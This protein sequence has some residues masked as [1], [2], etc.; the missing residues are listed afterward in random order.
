MKPL[1]VLPRRAGLTFAVAAVVFRRLVIALMVF[2]GFQEFLAFSRGRTPFLF[3]AGF[4][5]DNLHHSSG[6][7]YGTSGNYKDW[8]RGPE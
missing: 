2:N 6:T 1:C 5:M 4:L 3:F 7:P 8:L